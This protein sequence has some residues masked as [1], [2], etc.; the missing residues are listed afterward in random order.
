[1]NV[2]KE[3]DMKHNAIKRMRNLGVNGKVISEF[4]SSNSIY[5]SINGGELVKLND[6]GLEVLE[7]K[8]QNSNV[9]PFH[10]VL[11]NSEH[12]VVFNVLYVSSCKGDWDYG[13]NL[14]LRNLSIAKAI[15]LQSGS[16]ED[17]GPIKL[18]SI[19]GV[20]HEIIN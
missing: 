20:L 17:I 4:K 6:N 1:M 14:T 16:I 19:N 3:M 7:S 2:K 5:Q 11:T 9:M 13:N 8:M 12:G 15:N 18:K 10:I